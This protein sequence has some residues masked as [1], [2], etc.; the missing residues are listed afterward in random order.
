[1]INFVETY[2]QVRIF[3][4]QEASLKDNHTGLAYDLIS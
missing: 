2:D 1:M 3:L 4:P